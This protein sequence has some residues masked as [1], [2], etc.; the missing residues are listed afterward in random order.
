MRRRQRRHEEVVAR[1][2]EGD[3][4]ACSALA[5]RSERGRRDGK[6]KLGGLTKVECHGAQHSNQVGHGTGHEFSKES[7]IAGGVGV[8]WG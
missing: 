7:L 4:V 2:A 5:W 1:D 3:E 6:A 8:L